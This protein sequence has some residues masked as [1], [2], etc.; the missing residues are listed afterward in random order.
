MQCTYLT[1]ALV[2]D[3]QWWNAGDKRKVIKMKQRESPNSPTGGRD[4]TYG[5]LKLENPDVD[6]HSWT[7][8]ANIPC[9]MAANSELYLV[10]YSLASRV[11]VLFPSSL[12]FLS[13]NLTVHHKFILFQYYDYIICFAFCIFSEPCY[14]AWVPHNFFLVFRFLLDFSFYMHQIDVKGTVRW[15]RL[16]Q[17]NIF[18]FWKA[19]VLIF[20][21]HLCRSCHHLLLAQEGKEDRCSQVSW[22]ERLASTL[23]RNIWIKNFDVWIGSFQQ[24]Q[25]HSARRWMYLWS[26]GCRRG[27]ICLEIKWE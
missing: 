13:P 19:K 8:A 20:L 10:C 17:S 26:W 9:L 4:E 22:Y 27:Y 5:V 2:H 16:D 25:Q 23:P 3:D 14:P 24:G 6:T 21:R 12:L 15:Q 7:T 18:V 1:F 11:W